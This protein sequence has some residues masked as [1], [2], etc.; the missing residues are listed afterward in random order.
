MKG[1]AVPAKIIAI[2]YQE[3]IPELNRLVNKK[4]DL[5][6]LDYLIKRLNSMTDEEL[7][8]FNAQI[9]VEHM[10]TLRDMINAT[11][12]F[13]KYYVINDFKLYADKERLGE[14]L[15]KAKNLAWSR[16]ELRE[17]DFVAYAEEIKKTCPMIE[18]PYGIAVRFYEDS[19]K[20]YTE[21]AFP[22]FADKK[23]V[24]SVKITN[25][26]SVPTLS[27]EMTLYLPENK[28]YIKAMLKRIG[29][30]E[31]VGYTMEVEYD[32]LEEI[33]AIHMKTIN[34]CD[35][36]EANELAEAIEN[37]QERKEE[38]LFASALEVIPYQ[39]LQDIMDVIEHLNHFEF[40]D[41]PTPADYA[42]SYVEKELRNDPMD[43]FYEI[44]PFI[45]YEGL[46][47][48]L[49]KGYPIKEVTTGYLMCPQALI[50]EIQKRHADQEMKI[51]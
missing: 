38:R 46:G 30:E 3:Q 35:V 19:I 12:D 28:Y 18:T 43:I 2:R 5:Y 26:D 51:V 29:V 10:D 45:D 32:S 31:G 34:I 25:T 49:C 1:A 48:M 47:E 16:K 39:T 7:K 6:E 27:S 24:M 13:G 33:T 9:Y 44:D 40:S 37:I 20:M 22:A 8:N 4:V 17:T 41:G 36:L 21:T 50:D 23:S 11:Y 14:E 42:K 15:F